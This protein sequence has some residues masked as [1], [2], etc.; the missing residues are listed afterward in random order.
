[1]AYAGFP[2]EC[3]YVYKIKLTTFGIAKGYACMS[4]KKF[5]IMW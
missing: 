2:E 5:F 1:M 3:T 4:K